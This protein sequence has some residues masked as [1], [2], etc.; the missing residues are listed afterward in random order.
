MTHIL[1]SIFYLLISIGLVLVYMAAGVVLLIGIYWLLVILKWCYHLL[2]PRQWDWKGAH[3]RLCSLCKPKLFLWIVVL[4][5][6]FNAAF[7][8]HQRL[9]WMDDDNDNLTAK[10]YYVA[11][12]VLYFYRAVL[13]DFVYPGKYLWTR[14][15][16]WLQ[17]KIYDRGVQYLPED[18]GEIGIWNDAW[19]IYPYSKRMVKPYNH[20]HTWEA[21]Q[22]ISAEFYKQVWFN[23]ETVATRKFR[24]RQMYTQH[25]LRNFAGMAHYYAYKK[26]GYAYKG[27]WQNY[28]QMFHLVE[29]DKKL[30]DWLLQL[31]QQWQEE[32]KLVRFIDHHPK[33]EVMRQ[34]AII[35]E[36]VDIIGSSIWEKSFSCDSPYLQ[37]YADIRKLF[38]K[39]DGEGKPAVL[40]MHNRREAIQFTNVAINSK[41]ARFTK[42]IMKQYCGFEE[43]AGQADMTLYTGRGMT[44]DEYEEYKVRK[45]LFA[46]EIKLLEE[47]INE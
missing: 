27:F 9:D 34:V 29:R 31:E 3:Q 45:V 8:M 25:Y 30:V 12:Q 6:L 23:L 36:L 35:M 1:W 19:F 2:P 40:R 7:Y 39:G 38:A 21:S 47:Q 32:E 16:D 37:M 14:P 46:E 10:E 18:D 26:T 44:P 13:F 28:V 24:D 43:V 42:Y 17:E 41:G 22:R 11:G 33:V 15:L 4:F 5:T 20:S